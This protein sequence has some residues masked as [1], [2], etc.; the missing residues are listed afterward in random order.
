MDLTA[1]WESIT[2]LFDGDFF[3]NIWA[4]VLQAWDAIVALFA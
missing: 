4:Y 3:A 2:G 1:I